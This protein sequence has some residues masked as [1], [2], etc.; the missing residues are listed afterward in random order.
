MNNTPRWF[1]VLLF[2][3]ITG[4]NDEGLVAPP[5]TL[6]KPTLQSIQA[7]VFNNCST[8]SCHGAG[9][10]G[11][12]ILIEGQSYG[13]LVNQQSIGDGDHSPKFYRIKPFSVDSSFLYI[14]LTNPH[15]P[16]QGDRMPQTSSPLPQNVIDAIRQWIG[17]GAKNN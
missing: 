14:K 2:A 15:S 12:L 13:Q 11:G 7:V 4:C 16:S 1:F 17:Q 8:P 9:G 5:T 10:K 6:I 3:G